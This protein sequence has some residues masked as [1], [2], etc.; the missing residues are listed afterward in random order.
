MFALGSEWVRLDAGWPL[1]WV[2]TDLVPGI[3]FLLCGLV[4]WRRRSDN[5]VG[6]LMVAT[7]FAWYV[8][9]YTATIDPIFAR[10]ASGFQGWYDAFLAWLVLA[11][12]S[13]RLRSTGGRAVIAVFLGWLAVRAVVRI[14]AFH[15]STEYDLGDPAEIDRFVADQMF[16]DAADTVFRIGIAVLA[17]AVLILVVVRLRTETHLGRRIAGPI[18]LGGVAFA[19]GILVE[20]WV[21]AA[22][23]GFAERSFAWET[24][25]VVTIVTATLVPI[26]FLW[27][28]ARAR[29]GRTAVAD[30]VVELGA[31]ETPR[32]R[33][34][35]ARALQDPSLQ[36][37]YAEV[38]DGG[39]V[40][41]AGGPVSLPASNDPERAMTRLEVGGRTVAVLIHDAALA[42]QPELVRPVAAAAALAIENE[43]LAADVQAQLE[44]VRRSR[45][46]IVAAGD[47]A[48]RRLERDIHDGAQQRL[49][50][51]ALTLQLARS[52]IEATNPELAVTLAAASAELEAALAE[53]RQL[54]RG[55]HPAVLVEEGLGPAVEALAD[56]T[57]LPVLVRVVDRR[58]APD[59]EATAYFVVAEAL[60]NV[61]KHAGA[62]HASVEIEPI[63]DV[64]VAQVH[65]DGDGGASASRGSGLAGLDDRVAAAGGTLIVRSPAGGG[66]T[67]RAEIPC[68]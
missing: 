46:R 61:Q 2:V 43:R 36:I 31:P 30:L 37:A 35:L 13:G 17:V 8:G 26:G 51:L 42:E 38:G 16:R 4:A 50:T 28:L 68:A 1:A 12:P 67:I 41:L 45:A 66:T 33:D 39:F 32:L 49:V 63:G 55:L 14:A 27:G 29:L 64:L 10:I 22:A 20:T 48:R 6:P 7:G 59:V 23:E 18:L 52:D 11:F 19:I 56:R 5:R 60:T 21:I 3:V 57:P 24:G 15:M 34:V 58:F 40:D 47:A 54:A 44:A 62:S 25:R 65:D 53:L 9:T